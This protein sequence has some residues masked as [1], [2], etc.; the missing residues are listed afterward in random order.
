MIKRIKICKGLLSLTLVLS[1]FGICKI[2]KLLNDENYNKCNGLDTQINNT[3]QKSPDQSESEEMRGLWVSFVDLEI[4]SSE[5]TQQ[6]FENKF[7]DII[8][9][10][11]KNKINNLFVHVRSHG[12]ALYP[13][14]IFPFSH[15]LTGKQTETMS[16]DPLKY[17]LEESH[18]NG[19]KFHAW[20]NPLRVQLRVKDKI[21]PKELCEK[22]P[23]FKFDSKK[24][25]IYHTG[26]ICY[27]PAFEEVQKLVVDGVDEIV[28]NYDVDGI[29]FDDYFYPEKRFTTSSDIA[30]E[31][32]LKTEKNPMTEGSW[33]QK[34]INEL[35]QK[36]YKS[37]KEI[38]PKVEFGIS[39]VGVIANCYKQGVDVKRWLS[40]KGYVDY[41]CP[42]IYWS[43]DFEVM[44]FEKTA[45]NW[46]NI[47]KNSEVKLY[48]GLALYKVGTD[49]DENTWKNQ[50]DI[51]KREVE[52]L[53]KFGYNG[54]ALFSSRHLNFP[55]TQTELKNF[56]S[57]M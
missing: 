49:C 21:S 8:K 9:Q 50:S 11:K 26:G 2:V 1:I 57:I 55:E 23:Y 16:F 52:I 15:I 34:H 18:K 7:Q 24:H 38:N 40:E 30:F 54:F 3:S 39:P 25:M 10:A 20:I 56:L 48:C 12:D 47:Q 14:K 51:L 33:R 17:M 43:T 46:K 19:L 29:H 31:E 53:R 13:S 4:N 37:I 45:K 36:V 27:N 41:V 32:Y 28:K 44:P 35:V 42:Q 22:N 6:K 5:D